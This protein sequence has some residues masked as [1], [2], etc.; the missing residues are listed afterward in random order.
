MISSVKKKHISEIRAARAKTTAEIFTPSKTVNEMLELLPIVTWEEN[1]TFLDPACGNGNILIEVLRRKLLLGQ[2]PFRALQTI[3]GADLMS[4]NI[5]ECRFRL[6]N[7]ISQKNEVT[8][9]MIRVVFS[10]VV[11]TNRFPKGSLDYDFSFS[12][13]RAE[14]TIKEWSRNKDLI[15]TEE[16][17]SEDKFPV[18]DDKV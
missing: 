8:E 17:S 2:D 4:D 3:Y 11:C 15:K 7:M 16:L 12:P 5:R 18:E 13:S 14:K 6:L 1:K 9:E 10:N